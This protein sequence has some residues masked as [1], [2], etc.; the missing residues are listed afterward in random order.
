[1]GNQGILV[2]ADF[3]LQFL[4]QCGLT[5]VHKLGK[6]HLLDRLLQVFGRVCLPQGNIIRVLAEVKALGMGQRRSESRHSTHLVIGVS[7][8]L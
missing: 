3:L 8:C 2:P 5:L 4:L 1:M 7:L 6:W